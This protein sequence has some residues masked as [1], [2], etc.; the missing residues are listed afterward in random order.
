MF[1][2][3]LK[4]AFR[5]LIKNKVYSSINI[6]GLAAGIACF[7][8][9]GLYISFEFS[10]D[11]YHENSDSIYRVVA[12]SDRDDNY[13]GVAKV[14][15]PWGESAL[16]NIPEVEAVTRFVFHGTSL[17]RYE[18][19]R[20]FEGNGF[21]ADSSVL[22]M[23]TFPLLEGDPKTALDS[24]NSIVIDE[25]FAA[26]FFGDENPMGKTITVSEETE[27]TVT[28]ILA[29]IPDN[30]HFT[31]DF[32]VSL[33][34][35]SHPDID[36]WIVWNQFYTYLK[37]RDG[38]NSKEVEIKMEQI[39][40]TNLP[41]DYTR[42]Y[43]ATLQPLT[44]IHLTSN[45]WREIT[46]N[47]DKST[48]LVY[49]VVGL[50]VLLLACINFINLMT[51]RATTRLKEVGIRKTIGA[52]RGAL[53][54]QFL[55]ESVLT[56]FI[57]LAFALLI[58]D[59]ILPGFVALA[60]SSFDISLM[61]QPLNIGVIL[62][63]AFF[64]SLMSGV[65]PAFVL[66]SPKP[67]AILKGVQKIQ[68]NVSLRKGLVVFQF[69]ASVALICSTLVMQKQF[70][71]MQNKKLGF[72]KEQILTIPIRDFSINPRYEAIKDRFTSIPGVRD[73]SFSGN[74][75][76]G[77]DWGIPY[78]AEGIDEEDEPSFRVLAVDHD[79]LD[80]YGMNIAE[81]R[82]FST[83]YSTDTQGSFL[84]NQEAA[85]QLGWEGEAI[86]KLMSI[87][88]DPN[89]LPMQD[90]PVVGV[91]E[92]FHFRSMKETIAPVYFFIPPP[93]WFA[94]ISVKIESGRTD[95][96]LDG[97]EN[98]WAEFDPVHPITVS[99][100]DEQYGRLHQVE[101]N[102]GQ[103]IS[104]L[105]IVAIIIACLGLFGLV[106]FSAQQRTKEIGIRKVLG[107]SVQGIVAL[108]SKEYLLLVL[109]GFFVGLP[110]SYYWISSWLNQFAYQTTVGIEVYLFTLGI[111][112]LIAVLAVLYQALKAALINPV[113]SLKSE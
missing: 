44:S 35:Y 13:D 24:P 60:N 50:F 23:F 94:N 32:L 99:F 51:A 105:T 67:S 77:S 74:M 104:Y 4:I 55:G 62:G 43:E 33:T 31:F 19:N 88:I 37:L 109:I 42:N 2:N 22:E 7:I 3:Y 107:S 6:L 49:G 45:L 26:R 78:S 47:S 100:F 29:N 87:D 30:S 66:S 18:N 93:N 58:V 85:R 16:L 61:L 8:L 73:V 28:G 12:T 64:I 27:Y 9:I 36:D 25:D 110:L 21:F 75:P 106:A 79:F 15:A 92:D 59:L 57:S 86:G 70:D 112:I 20:F 83:E 72:D 41:E 56:V 80:V 63:I 71:Y 90:K 46:L 103:L 1:K 53:I 96:V 97:L 10:F 65:Y 91:V 113:E 68:G 17:M 48:L 52:Q 38:A 40:D 34:S 81:G 11:N 108:L 111:T 84:I 76:G 89:V 82:G 98:A 95:E 39:L 54:R 14:T 102:A 69:T 101:E 5:N